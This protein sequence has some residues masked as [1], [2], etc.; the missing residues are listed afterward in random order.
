ML[1]IAVTL[2]VVVIL[3]LLSLGLVLP[4]LGFGVL[5]FGILYVEG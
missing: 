1:T 4:A 5:V 3:V 2:A